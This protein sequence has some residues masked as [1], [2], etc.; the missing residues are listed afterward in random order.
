M[1]SLVC[2]SS[3]L[4]ATDYRLK[5]KSFSY[6]ICIK[7]DLGIRETIQHLVMECPFYIDERN[8]MYTEFKNLED[9]TVN[10]ILEEPQQVFY[11]LMG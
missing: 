8:Q 3:K 4:K 6:K 11:T 7:C 2:Y 9:E 10:L 1:A 5:G